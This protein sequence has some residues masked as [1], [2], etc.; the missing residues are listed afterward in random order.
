MW[1]KFP[2][3]VLECC[4]ASIS[5]FP[6]R[7]LFARDCLPGVIVSTNTGMSL[8]GIRVYVQYGDQE[9][10]LL[11]ISDADGK[12]KMQLDRRKRVGGVL[13][14]LRSVF[15]GNRNTVGSYVREY[16]LRK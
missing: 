4:R 7:L 13:V 12:I 3:H 8:Q 6:L 15:L 9:P 11:A 5:H 14:E 10:E 2:R 16:R 1:V